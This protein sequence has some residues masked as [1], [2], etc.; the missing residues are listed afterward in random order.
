MA[1]KTKLK[2]TKPTNPNART[3]THLPPSRVNHEEM[4][5]IKAKAREFTGGNVSEWVRVASL[6]YV[7]RRKDYA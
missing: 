1:T 2:S 6:N 4:A 7:P 5:T 3:A